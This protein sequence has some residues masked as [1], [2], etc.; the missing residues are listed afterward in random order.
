MFIQIFLYYLFYSYIRSFSFL[1]LYYLR[2]FIFMTSF[3]KKNKTK[4][5]NII[6]LLFFL[7]H[8]EYDNRRLHT[9]SYVQSFLFLFFSFLFS[10]SLI[11]TIYIMT[12]VY[13]FSLIY[14]FLTLFTLFIYFIHDSC[15]YYQRYIFEFAVEQKQFH[16]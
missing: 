1:P 10:L 3:H 6:C 7:N 13:F 9:K 5:W 14:I 4:G 16:K 8:E 12:L 15:Y 11:V 2:T